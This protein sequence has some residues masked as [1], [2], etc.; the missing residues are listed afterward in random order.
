M[1]KRLDENIGAVEYDGL[2]VNNVPVA[3]VV[4]VKLAA[5]TGIL[6][7]GT[8]VTGAA[9]AELAPAAAAL[10]ATNGTIEQYIQRTGDTR[11]RMLTYSTNLGAA[12]ARNLGVNE[13]KGRYL[14]YL[15]ALNTVWNR[16]VRRDNWCKQIIDEY[17]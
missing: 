2:I 13:A 17:T 16:T 4:T 7:R 9:G 3:D 1:S 12:R 11:I 8:V 6:K 10:S 5:G 15:D 14:A